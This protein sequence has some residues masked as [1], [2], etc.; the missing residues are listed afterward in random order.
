MTKSTEQTP[1]LK[2]KKEY[3]HAGRDADEEEILAEAVRK[4]ALGDAWATKL[5]D[6]RLSSPQSAVVSG[7][8]F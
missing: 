2:I 4:Q 3:S 5:M 8:L 6:M 1:I 7:A